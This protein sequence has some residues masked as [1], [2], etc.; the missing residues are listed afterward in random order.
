MKRASLSVLQ[1]AGVA[2]LTTG[3]IFPAMAQDESLQVAPEQQP[4]SID[5]L[6]AQVT[7]A[8]QR[9][10]WLALEKATAM[11]E[12]TIDKNNFWAEMTPE[13]KSNTYLNLA[14]WYGD[15]AREMARY[16]KAIYEYQQAIEI[17]EERGKVTAEYPATLGKL[18]LVYR[19][20]G[21]FDQAL[22]F[23]RKGQAIGEPVFGAE[24]ID[25]AS[26]L[27]NV[28][29]TLQSLG[30]YDEAGEIMK[31]AIAIYE[32]A[33]GADHPY[34]GLAYNNYALIAQSKGDYVLAE[35]EFRKAIPVIEKSVGRDHEYAAA[36]YSGLAVVI[37][38]TG[39]PYEAEPLARLAITSWN[40]SKGREHPQTFTAMS[41]L[42]FI[43]TT[44]NRNEAAIEYFE[45]AL[46]GNRKVYGDAHPFSA[47]Y[48]SNL[49]GAYGRLRE[50]EKAIPYFRDALDWARQVLGPDHPEIALYANNLA[51][52]LGSVNRFDEARVQIENALR[53]MEQSSGLKTTKYV[54]A[55]A[56]L[57][58]LQFRTSGPEVALPTLRKAVSA[59]RALPGRP[60]DSAL[61]AQGSLLLALA[62]GNPD[63][64]EALELS[65][66]A[67]RFIA[68]R[69][70]RGNRKTVQQ[71][72]INNLPLVVGADN[73]S[74]SY[75]DIGF[76]FHMKILAARAQSIPAENDTLT[77]EMFVTAQD[78][79]LSSSARAMAQS[80]ARTAT[81]GG[82][83]GRLVRKQQDLLKEIRVVDGQVE[84]AL[85]KGDLVETRKLQNQLDMIAAD[86]AETD[87]QLDRQF[88][89]YR[90]L[91][92]PKALS[93]EEVQARLGDKDGLWLVMPSI[94]DIFILAVT[95][96]DIQWSRRAR[97]LESAEASIA[98][99]RCQIDPQGCPEDL[100]ADE[101]MSDAELEGYRSY[102]RLAAYRLYQELVELVETIF[103]GK[104]HIYAVA[105]GA[106]A[107]LPLA[108]LVNEKPDSGDNA[109]PEI[110]GKTGWLGERYAFT[111]LPAVSALGGLGGELPQNGATSSIENWRFTGFGAPLLEGPDGGENRAR[112]AASSGFSGRPTALVYR[113]PIRRA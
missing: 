47:L 72:E 5:Q 111:S 57:G 48:A 20:Q 78:S 109:D 37:N 38:E 25:N 44:Q 84:K 53:I 61:V 102:D 70:Q 74:G 105:S 51:A 27:G 76:G 40:N 45:R 6:V 42:A 81:G 7:A 75:D 98:R 19:A 88:P 10:D 30:R 11:I 58:L 86:L 36:A 41:N 17:L 89:E 16:P 32:K 113:L 59:A 69:R 28:A 68:D 33:A 64:D 39:R 3:L 93:V 94:G 108:A 91:V 97:R 79:T 73:L 83:L 66:E 34:T 99:L 24:S 2:F 107:T 13:E 35:Q 56:N 82:P 21:K 80:A 100:F 67:L 15:A 23:F 26:A 54:E 31:R 1:L 103:D 18:A 106:L 62:P 112:G 90:D 22:E 29:L 101:E 55:L 12:D 50:Y 4:L 46:A 104:D 87:A 95:R 96:E 52:A 71:G 43:L 63:S 60:G 14:I 77:R 49:G 65:R 85:I 9:R 8:Y 110:L 92:S